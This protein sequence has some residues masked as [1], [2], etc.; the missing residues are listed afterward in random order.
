MSTSQ[1]E[2]IFS[3]SSVDE[4]AVWKSHVCITRKSWPLFKSKKIA[5]VVRAWIKSKNSLVKHFEDMRLYRPSKEY[6]QVWFNPPKDLS[7]SCLTT[8]G[9]RTNGT[10]CA[11]I[12]GASSERLS[13]C[14]TITLSCT[15]VKSLMG[16]CLSSSSA[17][18]KPTG[19]NLGDHSSN[20]TSLSGNEDDMTLQNVY[21]LLYSLWYKQYSLRKR[22]SKDNRSQSSVYKQG[23]MKAKRRIESS[24]QKENPLLGW[25][26]KI[27]EED[28]FESE[29]DDIPATRIEATDFLLRSFKSKKEEQFHNRRKGYGSFMIQLREIKQESKEE[30]KEEDKGEENTR[31]RKQVQ[32]KDEVKKKRRFK[33]DY[34]SDDPYALVIENDEL[35]LCLTIG[36]KMRTMK[37]THILEMEELSI[38]EQK[39]Y[40]YKE[41]QSVNGWLVCSKTIKAK[42]FSWM[43]GVQD[44]AGGIAEK[45]VAELLKRQGCLPLK[46]D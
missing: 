8:K 16:H 24:V 37:I 39:G 18:P 12:E 34:F 17:T 36:S 9:M 27:E 43:Y 7:M 4:R 40:W 22:F 45:I 35:R 44:G 15:L 29:D 25:R 31:K 13:E 42:V 23:G 10:M 1:R 32:E 5:Q 26:K 46:K 33:Q 19:E 30:V 14:S 38:P 6:L 28:E 41:H 2:L 21:D 11:R 3:G 20:D